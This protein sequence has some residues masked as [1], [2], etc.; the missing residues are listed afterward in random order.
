MNK[1]IFGALILVLAIALAATTWAIAFA[2][3]PQYAGQTRNLTVTAVPLAV[4]EMQGTLG[5]LK[6]DFAPGGVLDGKEVYGFYPST[7]TVY[8]GDTVNLSLVNPADDDHTFTVS[9]M[10]VNTLMKGKSVAKVSFTAKQAGIFTFYCNMAEH[11]PYMWGQIV[12][13]PDSAATGE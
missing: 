11:V 10:G 9:G 6:D 13:L 12:V 1:K 8:K 7:I 4:H 3:G 2:S 5:Y